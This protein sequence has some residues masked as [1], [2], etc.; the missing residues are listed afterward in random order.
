MHIFSNLRV[1]SSK[2]SGQHTDTGE[3][4]R[5]VMGSNPCTHTKCPGT[6]TYA[7]ANNVA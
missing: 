1:N 3:G 7:L 4:E 2:P 5:V 6:Q